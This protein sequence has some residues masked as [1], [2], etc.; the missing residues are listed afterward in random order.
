MKTHSNINR[1]IAFPLKELEKQEQSKISRGK[2]IIRSDI[3]D[4]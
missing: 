3:Y 4:V 2:E 1:K